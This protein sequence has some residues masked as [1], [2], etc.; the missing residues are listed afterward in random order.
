ML[1]LNNL[2][3]PDSGWLLTEAKDINDAGQIVGIGI[4]DGRQ[5]AF[6]LTPVALPQ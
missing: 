4:V 2:T 6:L 5:H 1:D 3:P